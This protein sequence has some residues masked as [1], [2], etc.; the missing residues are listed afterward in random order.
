MAN[1]EHVKVV[2]QGAAAIAEWRERNPDVRLDLNAA[3][4]F[5]VDLRGA[6]LSGA[7]LREANL[8]AAILAGANVAGADL[9]G[10]FLL[11]A[12]L[13]RTDFAKA[14]LS[15]AILMAANLLGANLVG[16][17]LTAT[18]MTM[19][20]LLRANL[21]E[22]NLTKADLG[23]ANLSYAELAGANLDEAH[24]MGTSLGYADLSKAAGLG[25]VNHK[26]PSSIGVDTLILSFRGAGNRFTPDLEAFFLGAGVPKELLAELPRIVAEVK[27]Y[28]C[29]VCYGQPDLDFA[30]RL[31]DDLERRGVPCWLYA[32]DATPGERTW[33][34]I[35]RKRRE[36]DKMVVICS[37]KALIRPGVLKEIEEQIDE[38]PEK[39]VPISRDSLWREPGFRVMRGTNDL[40]LFLLAKNY[41]DFSDESHYEESLQR[42]LKAL[43]RKAD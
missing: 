35:G 11:G 9:T 33:G 7:N 3:E 30:T 26:G 18:H 21:T 42:L 24:L 6:N 34:E 16:A 31:C 4:L 38:D 12:N 41:A 14:D 13:L 15:E 28:S 43:R 8:T 25:S 27:Y 36:A 17:N 1:P 40:K 10:A 19:A 5:F 32:L 23:G 39:M 2:C 20:H 29:F 22:A 37:A